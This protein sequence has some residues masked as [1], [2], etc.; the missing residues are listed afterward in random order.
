MSSCP[1]EHQS[2][3]CW[4]SRS[5][6]RV[7]WKVESR[8]SKSRVKSRESEGRSCR[9]FGFYLSTF[10]S[11]LDFRLSTFDSR[12]YQYPAP[13][14][15]SLGSLTPCQPLGVRMIASTSPQVPRL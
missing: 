1:R 4:N 14:P 6:S 8:E 15:P 7:E 2:H 11:T 12:L 9:P 13:P 3:W 5:R 10:D